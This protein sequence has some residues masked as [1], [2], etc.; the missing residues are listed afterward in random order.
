MRVAI[1]GNRPG[2]GVPC[3]NLPQGGPRQTSDTAWPGQ[4][5]VYQTPLVRARS[6]PA[7]GPR[8]PCSNGTPAAVVPAEEPSQDA[9]AVRVRIPGQFR[10]AQPGRL[11]RRGEAGFAD[12]AGDHGRRVS[13]PCWACSWSSPGCCEKLRREYRPCCPKRSSKSWA[14]AP[15]PPAAGPPGPLRP[16]AAAGFGE[17]G[18]RRDAGRDRRPGWKSIAWPD[19][20]SRCSR[21]APRPPSARS[22]SNS[23]PIPRPRHG[24]RAPGRG[25]DLSGMQG[26]E[27]PPWLRQRSWLHSEILPVQISRQCR[28]AD[29]CACPRAGTALVL[30]ALLSCCRRRSP[31]RPQ[32][33]P[34]ARCR[35]SCPRD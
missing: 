27:D 1:G 9:A 20:A 4:Q 29:P 31:P 16:Q 12:L 21:E 3:G 30:A 11:A 35:S 7:L 33:R 18:G 8:P 15:W 5:V 14:C 25:A 32:E 34:T 28:P 19:C 22:S 26:T 13:W 23:P 17:P 24:A 2:A 6:R 10:P